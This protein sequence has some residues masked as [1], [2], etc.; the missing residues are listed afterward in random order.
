MEKAE[1]VSC[2]RQS[3]AQNQCI[4]EQMASLVVT[5]RN[6]AADSMPLGNKPS[7]SGLWGIALKTKCTSPFCILP[8][9]CKYTSVHPNFHHN[10]GM[11]N[12]EVTAWP[13]GDIQVP[14]MFIHI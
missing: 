2:A 13:S 14:Q 4:S 11:A 5:A 1:D 12:Y 8:Q 7:I 3:W 10:K 6:G 9:T